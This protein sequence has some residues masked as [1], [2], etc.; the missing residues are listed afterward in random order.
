MLWEGVAD[1]NPARKEEQELRAD[2]EES[3]YGMEA[4]AEVLLG[5][6]LPPPALQAAILSRYSRLS[7]SHSPQNQAWQGRL[8]HRSVDEPVIREHSQPTSA[9]PQ[10][11]PGLQR[12]QW[13]VLAA[14]LLHYKQILPFAGRQ[15]GRHG[16][17]F[18][19]SC[20]GNQQECNQL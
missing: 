17:S 6:L 9:Q 13:A 7:Y 16:P 5:L 12:G 14:G 18:H 10:S 8:W 2:L 20:H 11:L 1:R 3:R 4:G 15:A 19:L